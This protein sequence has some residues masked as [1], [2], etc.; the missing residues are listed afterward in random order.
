MIQLPIP[1]VLLQRLRFPSIPE[2]RQLLVP[3]ASRLDSPRMT[4]TVAYANSS[5]PQ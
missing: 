4:A 2:G 3:F 1:P 5:G